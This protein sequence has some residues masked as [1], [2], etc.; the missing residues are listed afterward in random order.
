[1]QCRVLGV[2]VPMNGVPHDLNPGPYLRAR[3]PDLLLLLPLPRSQFSFT[4]VSSPPPPPPTSTP[5]PYFL[6]RGIVHRDLKPHNVLI[7]ETG[8]AKLSDMGLSKQLVAEQS[9][10][11]SHGAGGSSGWQAPEQL[12]ARDGGAV[13][14]TRSMDVFSLGCVLHFVITGG[15][16]VGGRREESI[17]GAGW[18]RRGEEGGEHCRGEMQG[19]MEREERRWDAA[20]FHCPL[21]VFL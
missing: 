6:Q 10:F 17:A 18:R 19:G 16:V 14:Q 20:M 5:T 2:H 9:S 3:N 11:E 12:I 8:R 15:W 1:M 7:T 21:F 13:R 4:I